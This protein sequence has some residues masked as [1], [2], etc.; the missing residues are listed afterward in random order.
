MTLYE[1]KKFNAMRAETAALRRRH[2]EVIEEL[3][4]CENEA[5]REDLNRLNETLNRRIKK[6]IQQE[7]RITEEI[8]EITD[9]Q[10]RTSI[11]MHYF[12]GYS[13]NDVAD[14]IGGGNTDVS[15]KVYFNRWLRRNKCNE[16]ML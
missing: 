9:A 3:E 15:C 14:A 5:Y 10:I 1:L 16:R 11:F 12:D 7:I 2:I 4:T 8:A 6:N 13:W